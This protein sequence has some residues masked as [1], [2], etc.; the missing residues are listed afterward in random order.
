M[1]MKIRVGL[2]GLGPG[3]ENRHRPAL[4]A[5]SDRFEVRAV[6]D[7]VAH[8][9]EQVARDFQAEVCDGY[10][11][12]S[13]RA[14]VDAILMLSRQWYGILPIMAACEAGKS[15][16]CSSGWDLTAE[17]IAQIRERVLNAGIVIAPEFPNRHSPATLRLKELIATRL[18]PPRMLFCHQRL[19]REEQKESKH[20]CPPQD[21]LRHN[22]VELIDW[23]CFVVGRDPCAVWG[24]IHPSET[25]KKGGDY[26]M[27]SLDF[28]DVEHAGQGR[29]V[30]QISSGKY[31]SSKWTEAVSFRP[32][33]ML[34]VVCENGVAFVDLPSSLTWFDNFGRQMESLESER[35]A[36]E[37]LLAQFHRS[38]THLMRDRSG[39]DDMY[40]AVQVSLAARRAYDTGLRQS[41]LEIMTTYKF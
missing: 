27:M 25:A 1:P 7:Q 22:L 10:F 3:W 37:Q 24:I 34:Q 4:R 40:R 18:G 23:C 14:D 17:E 31:M 16:Y 41:L 2:V 36:F 35:P 38:V 26:E 30:A 29:V 9:A 12:L 15:I 6:C 32:P 8:R 5:L 19:T 21:H 39:L 13:R 11:A 20:F 28:S 33:S